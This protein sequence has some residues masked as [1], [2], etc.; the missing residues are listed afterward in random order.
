MIARKSKQPP[1]NKTNKGAS[2]GASTG[3]LALLLCGVP[4]ILLLVG[5]GGLSFGAVAFSPS[6]ASLTAAIG[7]LGVGGMLLFRRHRRKA[8]AS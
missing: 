1:D 7:V 8:G 4:C 2:F 3:V 5:L 6:V